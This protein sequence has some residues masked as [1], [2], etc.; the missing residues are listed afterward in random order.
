MIVNKPS[1]CSSCRPDKLFADPLGAAAPSW[2]GSVRGCR[3]HLNL[4]PEKDFK[5]LYTVSKNDME[6]ALKSPRR[7]LLS[8]PPTPVSILTAVILLKC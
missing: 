4:V 8:Q 6:S 7:Y 2:V 5:N 3:V 1:T